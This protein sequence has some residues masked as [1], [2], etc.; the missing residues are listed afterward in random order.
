MKQQIHSLVVLIVLLCVA[1]LSTAQDESELAKKTQNP[2]SDLISLPLQNNF[3]FNFGHDKDV[4]YV[5]NVQ[6][7]IPFHL[8]Q[9]WNLITRTIIPIINQPEILPDTGSEFGM[10][11]IQFTPFLSPAKPGKLIWGMGPVFL[12]PSA[13]DEKIGTGKWSIGPSAVVL[14]MNGP[15]VYGVLAQNLWSFAGE[16]D[17]PHVNQMLLQ[18][19]INHNF[20]GGWYVC[21]TPIITA[22]WNAEKSSDTWTVPVGGGGGKLFKIG[23]QPMNAQ[24]QAF[25]NVDRPTFGPEWTLRFQL[26]FLFPK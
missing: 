13:A 2:V 3:N 15:W 8:T 23:K 4:Q 21:S 11:D 14:T 16:S 9:N 22:N 18:L 7:V 1:P 26:Q 6:P 17:R 24:L 19:F 10:G 20:R 25:Y 12:F 5:L